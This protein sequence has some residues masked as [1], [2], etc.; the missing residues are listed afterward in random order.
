MNAL[1]ESALVTFNSRID[2]ASS[3]SAVLDLYAGPVL[4]IAKKF[5][6]TLIGH[7]GDTLHTGTP[8]AGTI[9]LGA[10]PDGLEPAP[11]TPLKGSAF[12]VF[13]SASR[14]VF[15]KEGEGEVIVAPSAAG[16]NTYV[17]LD[18]DC[19]LRDVYRNRSWTRLT[20]SS[21]SLMQNSDTK[22]YWDLTK[23]IYRFVPRR[24]GTSFSAHTVDESVLLETH[25]EG[26]EWFHE[27]ILFFDDIKTD[28]GF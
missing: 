21:L 13:L 1:P 24:V 5:S 10:Q 18:L 15:G 25:L 12:E 20:P 19:L 11:V 7:T 9:T 6:L 3:P 2:F 26:I 23:N 4:P 17:S 14:R 22:H 28:E 16:G 8:G 27:L